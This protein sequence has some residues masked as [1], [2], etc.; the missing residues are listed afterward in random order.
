MGTELGSKL[1]SG[2][3]SGNF[4]ADFT[5]NFV[6]LPE[7]VS[8]NEECGFVDFNASLDCVDY[9]LRVGYLS[10]LPVVAV[11]KDD[12]LCGVYTLGA[13]GTLDSFP[14]FVD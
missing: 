9:T 1:C 3:F 5:T 8:L 10:S 11:Y 6:S 4:T 2:L 12:D 7:G 13:E 14:L